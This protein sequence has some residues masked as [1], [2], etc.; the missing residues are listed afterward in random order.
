LVR[1]LKDGGRL[2]IPVGP[3]GWQQTLWLI[4][5]QGEEVVSKSVMGVIFVPFTGEHPR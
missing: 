4:E 2:V 1:Q 3:P 5:K